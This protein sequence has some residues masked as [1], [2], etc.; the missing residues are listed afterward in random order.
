MH[1]P[2]DDPRWSWRFNYFA[3]MVLP[4]ILAQRDQ[5]FDIC[6]RANKWH[7]KELKA[8]S[9]KIKIFDVKEKEKGKIKKGYEEKAK[10]YFVDFVDFQ[11]TK[12]LKR[13]DIQIGIDS[14]DMPIN[15][16]FVTRLKKECINRLMTSLHVG[17]Q[18]YIFEAS[19]LRT[20]KSFRYSAERGSP[21]FALYQP[22]KKREYVFA[23]EDSHLKLPQ[24]ME[25]SITISEGY[26]AFSVHNFNSSTRL[27]SNAQQIRV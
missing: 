5:D 27:G 21:I 23:Y 11:D 13:Y 20:F 22:N 16:D 1:F 6:I 26:C 25:Q 17:F 19:T 2:K 18:P 3:S 10:I 9:P 15:I 8:L 14:D 24:Y 7:A 4:K 12:G